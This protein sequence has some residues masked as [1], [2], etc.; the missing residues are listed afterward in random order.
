MSL[1]IAGSIEQNVE[2]DSFLRTGRRH[3]LAVGSDTRIS[4]LLIATDR[5]RRWAA[6]RTHQVR[7]VDLRHAIERVPD[8]L[9]YAEEYTTQALDIRNTIVHKM[10]RLSPLEFEGILRPAFHQDEW[11]LIAVGAVIGFLVGELQVLV[12]PH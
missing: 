9:R 10:L 3:R 7:H 12:F 8:T 11:K 4:V 2:R 5:R 6:G 1:K